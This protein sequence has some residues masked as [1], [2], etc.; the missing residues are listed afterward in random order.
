[1]STYTEGWETLPFGIFKNLHNLVDIES[2]GENDLLGGRIDIQGAVFLN[3]EVELL[4][5][6][7]AV[8]TQTLEQISVV[9]GEIQ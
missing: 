8:H 2:V 6:V 3:N 5:I 7:A 9:F 4:E 1:M